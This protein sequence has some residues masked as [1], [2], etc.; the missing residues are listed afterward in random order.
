M[1]H[2]SVRVDLPLK[3]GI[4]RLITITDSLR[5]EITTSITEEE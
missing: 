1:D 5:T 3:M 4:F 2:R